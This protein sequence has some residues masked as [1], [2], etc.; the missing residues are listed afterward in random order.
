MFPTT[1]E[2]NGPWLL[3]SLNESSMGRGLNHVLTD[4]ELVE[5]E[6]IWLVIWFVRL[7]FVPLGG[8]PQCEREFV[9]KL[10]NIPMT[11]FNDV[12]LLI[13]NTLSLIHL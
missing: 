2:H 9:C 10:C 5:Q 7:D 12:Y 6:N 4:A 3:H 11:W 8:R 13:K 1:G